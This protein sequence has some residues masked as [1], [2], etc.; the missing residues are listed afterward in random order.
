[1]KKS[2]LLIGCAISV[3][4]SAQTLYVSSNT[5]LYI[6]QNNPSATT[7]QV[8]GAVQNEGTIANVG[9]I[10][11]TTDFVNNGT[12]KGGGTL[13]VGNTFTN[14]SAATVAPYNAAMGKMVI[15][16]SYTT[17]NSALDIILG[18]TTAGTTHDQ[19]SIT[20]AANISNGTL[21]VG[22]ASGYAPVGGESYTILD[23]AVLSGT[24]A[25]LNLPPLP[26]GLTWAT[27]YDSSAG[28][29]TLRVS[30][31]PLP[32]QLLAFTGALREQNV[33]LHWQT[34]VEINSRNFVVMRSPDAL[35]F[36]PIGSLAAKGT[37]ST[38]TFLDTKPLG[39]IN[40]YRL[41]I[42][43]RDDSFAYSNIIAI[44][45]PQQD[46][47]VIY[48]NPTQQTVFI[49]TNDRNLNTQLFDAQGKLIYAAPTVPTDIDLSNLPSGGYFLAIDKQITRIIKQ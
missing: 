8:N 43:D 24:F 1:M 39:G 13:G 41:Q 46:A 7:V 30:N 34:A 11:Y 15:I 3:S 14:S 23:A 42:I 27:D 12:F 18:G 28:T 26:N 36:E 31:T 17:V 16:G 49:N 2:I 10:D 22:F 35:N 40:Y 48:P 45:T 33:L 20:G 44:E 25:T 47:P 37:N 21:N 9:R 5:T 6:K 19:L 29:V 38:Y 32:V 4:V